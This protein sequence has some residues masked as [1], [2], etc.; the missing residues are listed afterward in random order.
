MRYFIQ[1]AYNGKAYHGW[2]TQPDAVSVQEVLEQALSMLLT[3]SISIVG[4]G[5]TDAGVHA[6][7][8]VAHFDTETTFEEGNLAFRLNA[9]LPKDIVIYTIF[10]VNPEVHARFD[11][12]AR[13]YLYRISTQKDPFSI[14]QAYFF[15]PYLDVDVMNSACKVL[16]NYNDFQCFSKS[17]T[18]V[19][20]YT[21]KIEMAFWEKNGD[22]LHFRI[23]ADRFLRNMVRAIVGTM[24]EIGTGKISVADLHTIIRSKD[25]SRAGYSVPAHGLY[26][27]KVDYPKDIFLN[28]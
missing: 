14:E 10:K 26:L 28:E 9:F 8:M 25:R 19:K 11:A 27:T 4:A 17:N 20:T 15:R 18:D 6:T 1:L 3:D 5:R 24:I 7:E 22:E 2:Q 12:V 16:F 23:S 13:S 21:C